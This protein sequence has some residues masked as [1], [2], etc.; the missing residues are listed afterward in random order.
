MGNLTSS[1]VVRLVDDVSGKAGRISKALA[2]AEKQTRALAVA[3]KAG[4]SERMA[5]QLQ[6]LGAGA[7]EIDRVTAAWQSYSRAQGL[8]ANSSKW[9]KDQVRGVKEWERANIAALRNVQTQRDRAGRSRGTAAARAGASAGSAGSGGSGGYGIV[10]LARSYIGPVVAAYALKSAVTK[11]AEA[12]RAI[13]RIGVTADVS[14]AA[15]TKVGDTAY[16]IAQ[17]AAVPYTKVVQGLNTL[18][19]QGRT[20]EDSMAFLPAVT[21]TASAADAEVEDIAKTADSVGSNFKIAG[22]EMQKAFDIMAAGGKAGQ[23]ELKDMARYLPSLGPAAAAAG[24]RGEEGLRDLVSMLQIMRKGSG[25]S[26]EAAGSM[27]NV[28]QKMMSEETAK[29]FKKFG[30]DLPKAMDKARKE[31]RNLV[32]VF[33]ELTHT[34]LK[35]DLSKIP[36]LINDM[37]FARGVRAVMTYR[38]EWQKLSGTIRATAGGT[39]ANDLAKVTDNVQARLDRLANAY[40]RRM[41]QLGTLVSDI[42]VPIDK[43]IDEIFSG[44]NATFNAIEDRAK[45]YNGDIIARQEMQSG[46]RGN[47]DDDTRR[48]VDARREFLER[49]AYDDMLEKLD[50][51]IEKTAREI[52]WS[53][54]QGKSARNNRLEAVLGALSGQR[55]GLISARKA[56]DEAVL[57]LAENQAARNRLNTRMSGRQ[58]ERPGPI[59]P[60]LVSFGFGPHGAGMQPSSAVP[61]TMTLPPARPSSLPK[62][63]PVLKDFNDIFDTAEAKAK[64][65]GETIQSALEITARPKVDTSQ[66]DN[67]IARVNQLR[68]VLDNVGGAAAGAASRSTGVVGRTMRGIHADG[69]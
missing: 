59:T 18:V 46:E 39:V 58:D 6:R 63:V 67:A 54:P 35:G 37:E 33:E 42:I 61:V 32:E 23:F 34:A 19:A 38:G 28:L 41:R 50:R 13:T 62:A 10:P 2:L 7:R 9:T 43:K 29:R 31:G 15:L 22:A 26:E 17:E 47:Y 8:A 21:R 4:L 12:E 49:Q 44:K 51:D 60:G 36:Q 24:F 11:G 3:S 65:A 57:G 40:E 20:L 48:L 69:D 27:Q 55:E 5:T 53:K 14:A 64:S 56:R 68:S 1:L 66:I 25:T 45:L 16:S 30:V 52:D